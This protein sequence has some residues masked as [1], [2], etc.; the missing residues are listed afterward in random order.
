MFFRHSHD[1]STFLAQLNQQWLLFGQQLLLIRSIFLYMDRTF[2]LNH[3]TVTPLWEAGLGFYRQ[4]V[5]Q[6]ADVKKACIE[7]L[8]DQIQA[9]R[10]GSK[11]DQQLIKSILKMLTDLDVYTL[12]FEHEFLSA[13]EKF[14]QQESAELLETLPTF[15]YLARCEERISQELKRSEVYLDPM[16]KKPL[17][18]TLEKESIIAH[19]PKILDK[20]FQVMIKENKIDDLARLYRLFSRIEALDPIRIHFGHYLRAVGTQ[21]VSQVD[22]DDTIVQ[23]LLDLK[24]KSDQVLVRAF[25]FQLHSAQPPSVAPPNA[26][27]FKIPQPVKRPVAPHSPSIRTAPR[28]RTGL[29]PNSITAVE[30]KVDWCEKFVHTQQEAF[31]SF[32]NKRPNKS[33]ELIAKYVDVKLRQG[34]KE[35]SE[36]ELEDILQQVLFLFRFIQGKDIFEAFFKKD[37]AKR[38]LLGKSSSVELEKSV[39]TKLKNECGAGFT[40]KLEGMFKDMEISKDLSKEFKESA[41]YERL[42][43]F[44]LV[45]NV[46]TQG[47]WPTYPPAEVFLPEN[48]RINNYYMYITCLELNQC[49]HLACQLPKSLC[50]ILCIQTSR[51]KPHMAALTGTLFSKSPLPERRQRTA[52][53]CIANNHF[54]PMEL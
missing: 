29:A 7:L 33:S 16:T 10:E 41:F 15:E 45:V 43:G 30:N 11:V 32:L 12:F 5:I 6:Q 25:G 52:P 53:V 42:N 48:V 28:P 38:L 31:E 50:R 24:T 49:L 9:E 3:S 21:I 27:H 51:S 46:L 22:H 54:T 14:Y 37:L 17:I 18:H 23:E 36:A 34:Y 40:A 4:H 39:L 1:R 8:L 44:D 13:T 35:H 19:I 2:L 47:F 20:G 26:P